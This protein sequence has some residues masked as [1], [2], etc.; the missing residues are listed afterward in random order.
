MDLSILLHDNAR[1]HVA[2]A[3]QENIL[4]LDWAVLPHLAYSPDVAPFDYHLF[5]SMV[6]RLAGIRFPKVKDIRKFMD[7]FIT[8]KP[9]SFYRDGIHML[10]N[11]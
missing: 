4:S 8:L 5:R 1:P 7:D 11:R 9:A 10:S 3:T 2:C 6:H